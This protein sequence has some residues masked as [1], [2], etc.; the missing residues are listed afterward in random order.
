MSPPDRQKNLEVEQENLRPGPDGAPPRPATEPR[1]A[2]SSQQ[3]RKTDTDPGSGAATGRKTDEPSA[4]VEGE[5][6]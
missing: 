2:E 4:D 6:R 5:T 1:G 3:S